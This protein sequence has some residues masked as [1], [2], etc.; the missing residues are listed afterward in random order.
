MDRYET[1]R[2]RND[3]LFKTTDS[4]TQTSVYF[5]H[6]NPPSS[7]SQCSLLLLCLMIHDDISVC[8]GHILFMV[9]TQPQLTAVVTVRTN[10]NYQSLKSNVS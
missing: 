3:N 10:Q 2:Q 7:T 1:Q 6:T 8:T 4:F 9:T 5:A